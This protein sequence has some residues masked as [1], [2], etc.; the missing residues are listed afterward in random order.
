MTALTLLICYGMVRLSICRP[1][2]LAASVSPVEA[3][4][5]GLPGERRR[6]RGRVLKERPAVPRL[7]PRRL[8]VIN[9]RRDRRK[10]VSI[11]ASISI[12]GVLL[13]AASTLLLTYSPERMARMDYPDGD[14]KLYIESDRDLTD[15]FRDGNPLSEKLRE[16]VLAIDGVESVTASRKSAGIALETE[17]D[18][19]TGIADMLTQ[20]NQDEVEETLQ[21][22]SMPDMS[23]GSDVEDSRF[24]LVSEAYTDE[25]G[26]AIRKGEKLRISLGGEWTE[27]TV[28]GVFQGGPGAG[29]GGLQLD[30]AGFYLTEEMFQE[31]LPDLED[32]DYS[33]QI[34][35]RQ[36]SEEQVEQALENVARSH[37]EIALETFEERV[38]WGEASFSFLFHILQGLASL[39]A[40]LGVVNLINTTLSNQISRQREISA[41]RCVGL[42]NR[43]LGRMAAW[44]GV[45]YAALSILVTVAAGLPLSLLLHRYS[46]LM[47]YSR[48]IPYE[49][50]FLYMGIYGA[51]LLGLECILSVWI[52][53]RQKKQPL[54]E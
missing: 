34:R 52:V 29:H 26:A 9:F 14:F 51:V 12:G 8:G 19:V 28:S 41:M 32:F 49:F 43:Q 31:L 22:G 33:W 1:A 50:P 6:E 20:E 11:L 47:Q 46:S 30:S 48:V 16:E 45:S 38:A 15:I 17:D 25:D 27:V 3:A 7:T 44:E 21:T 4:R 39:I 37:R 35:A 54:I 18:T 42:T 10:V 53:K 24:I 5:T 13:L 23:E 36:G 40:L 2:K